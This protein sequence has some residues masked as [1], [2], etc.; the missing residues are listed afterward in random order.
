MLSAPRLAKAA[1][2]AA[3]PSLRTG[4]EYNDNPQLTTQPHDSVHGYS[5]SP[6]LNLSVSSEIWQVAGGMAFARKRYPGNSNL[7]RDDQRYSLATSYRTERS[8]WEL[9]GSRSETS[10]I[11]EEQTVPNTGLVEVP[12]IYDSHRISPLWTWSMSELT[13]LQLAYSVSDFSYVN[14]ESSGLYDYS[15]RTATAQLSSHLDFKD[16]FFFIVG[17]S[18]FNVPATTFNSQSANYQAGITRGFSRTMKGTLIAGVR[19]TSDEQD[20]TVCTLSF[21]SLCLQTE[22]VT[23]SSDQTSSVYSGNLE[24][25]YETLQLN[26]SASRSYD[27][28][29]SGTIVLTD[30]QNA[31]LTKR[32]TS[33][34]RGEISASNY[35]I[36]PQT[37][38][39]AGVKRHF[40]SFETDLFW[41]WTRELGVSFHYRYSHV[42]RETQDQAAESNAVYLS[43]GYQWP[44]MAF[45]R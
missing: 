12:V 5:I 7:D 11:A 19:K 40:Y 2:W 44:K 22:R 39:I 23:Q 33:R 36:S 8:S 14:G 43:I 13:Q 3:E 21:G 31:S 34:L 26:L 32:F 29:G 16:R 25:K 41:H 18:S 20:V 35:N 10:T 28:S 17:Y 15:A 1:E 27:P 42:R 4:L 6:K 45:S 30:T 9:T 38:D 24:K 37:V